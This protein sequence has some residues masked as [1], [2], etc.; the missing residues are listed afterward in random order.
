MP[1]AVSRNGIAS[2]AEYIANRKTPR[3]MFSVVA[4]I[5]STAAR[6]GPMHK[7]QL[8]LAEPSVFS[9]LAAL[10]VALPG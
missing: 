10:Q 7:P 8:P 3:P 9:G 1:N 4:A 5:V 2:P 6:M